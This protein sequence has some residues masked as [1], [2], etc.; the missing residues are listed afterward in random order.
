MVTVIADKPHKLFIAI[1]LQNGAELQGITI[2]VEKNYASFYPL[3]FSIQLMLK[4]H[5]EIPFL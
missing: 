1:C 3:Y 5:S 2:P 4:S